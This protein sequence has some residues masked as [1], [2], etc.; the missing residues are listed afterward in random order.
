[1]EVSSVKQRNNPF[2]KNYIPLN[3]E[4]L[5]FH[6]KPLEPSALPDSFCERAIDDIR[7]LELLLDQAGSKIQLDGL[8]LVGHHGGFWRGSDLASRPPTVPR[9]TAS[10]AKRSMSAKPWTAALRRRQPDPTNPAA[11]CATRQQR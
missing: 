9:D 4:V 3:R 7:G 11:V 5:V 1:V 2:I 8:L 10:S 6:A